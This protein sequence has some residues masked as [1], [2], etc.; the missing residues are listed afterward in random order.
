MSY[1]IILTPNFQKEFKKLNKKYPSLKADLIELTDSLLMQPIQGD[2]VFK[3]CYKVR[4]AIKSKG[5]GKSGGARLINYVR[6]ED[7]KIY[8]L[9]VYDKSEKDTVSDNDIKFLLKDL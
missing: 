9:S 7:E 2:L 1:K 8:F 5:K 6:I 4:F 3:N